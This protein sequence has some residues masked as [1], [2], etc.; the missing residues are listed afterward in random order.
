MF[1]YSSNTESGN[2]CQ[3]SK[4]LTFSSRIESLKFGQELKVEIVGQNRNLDFSSKIET[5]NFGQEFKVQIFVKNQNLKFWLK[6][7]SS[8]FRQ[9]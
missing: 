6:I 4:V 2:F 8:N 1:L 7:E 9:K 3:K 5:S